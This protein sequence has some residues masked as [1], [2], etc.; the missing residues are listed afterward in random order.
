MKHGLAHIECLH[1]EVECRDQSGVPLLKLTST[2]NL[3]YYCRI[4]ECHDAWGKIPYFPHCWTN[5]AKCYETRHV[6]Q[7]LPELNVLQQIPDHYNQF[8]PEFLN[9]EELERFANGATPAN[10]LALS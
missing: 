2:T 6:G 1:E 10:S 7:P 3:I 5:L 4:A 9:Q 8:L